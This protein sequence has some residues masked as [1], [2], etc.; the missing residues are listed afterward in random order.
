M[1]KTD[2]ITNMALQMGITQKQSTQYLNTLLEIVSDDL[3]KGNDLVLQNFGTFTLWNQTERIGRN[4]RTGETCSIPARK[5]IKFKVGKG[6][7]KKVNQI[8]TDK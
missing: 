4:P 3:S 7:I 2:L 8:K 6:L 1:N 5:S